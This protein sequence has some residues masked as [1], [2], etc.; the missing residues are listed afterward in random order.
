M[1]KEG[2]IEEW[3][4]QFFRRSEFA[5]KCGCGFDD[6]SLE[7]VDRLERIRHIINVPLIVTS[8]CRCPT[9]NKLVGGEDGSAHTKGKAAD[10]QITG[11]VMRMT[12]TTLAVKLFKRIGQYERF[13]HLDVD[14]SL[15]Q[16]VMWW[17][18]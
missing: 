15:P 11:S 2:E 7:L 3:K 1:R 8:G 12:L 6:V 14:E 5:C 10:I 16:F 18:K 17:K 13:I 4:A 9:Y